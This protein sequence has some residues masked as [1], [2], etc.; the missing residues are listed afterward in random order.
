MAKPDTPNFS[1]FGR[2][3]FGVIALALIV[4]MLRYF[5]YFSV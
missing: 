4:M 1:I 2:I 5:G 3:V